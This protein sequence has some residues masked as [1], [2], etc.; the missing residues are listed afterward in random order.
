MYK[1]F[2]LRNYHCANEYTLLYN[3]QT[4]SETGLCLALAC[5]SISMV[6]L[7]QKIHD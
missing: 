1:D 5:V 6:F 3:S 2:F 7:G 4:K